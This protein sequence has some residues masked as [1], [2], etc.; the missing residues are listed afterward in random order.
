MVHLKLLFNN[1]NIMCYSDLDHF[2][3]VHMRTYRNCYMLFSASFKLAC[4]W[5]SCMHHLLPWVAS[6][7]LCH[8]SCLILQ[9]VM[10]MCG[11]FTLLFASFR[12]CFFSIVHVSSRSW[13][14]VHQRLICLRP[15][16][17]LMDSF[18]FPAGF[19]ARWPLPWISLLSLLC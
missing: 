3:N 7:S 13:G 4:M 14:F 18:F 15:F 5:C 19:Q 6:Y 11:V 8:A 2:R 10:F 12:L 9:H 17:F 1:L 16:V